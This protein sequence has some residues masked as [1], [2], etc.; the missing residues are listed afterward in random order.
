MIG[1]TITGG[2]ELAKR[3]ALAAARAPGI[4]ERK[5][6]AAAIT[7]Q[8]EVRKRMSDAGGRHPFFGRTGGRGF[9]LAARSGG[10]RRR[11][12]ASKARRIGRDLIVLVGTTD[13]HI[14]FMEDGGTIHG[15]QY[16][17][18]PLAAAQ[19][20]QGVDRWAGMSIRDIPG[21][22]LVRTL[23]GRLFAAREA[24]GTRSRRIELLYMLKRSVT[25][26]GRKV[27]ETS[28]R[29]AEPRVVKIMGDAALEIVKVANGS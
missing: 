25:H 21:A 14:A 11:V 23:R 27:F 15:N 10:S 19:T 20:A 3:L 8:G 28:R 2:D 18:I 29:D 9:T 16:L 6:N 1:I 4:E 22:F 17:R 26:R 12:V 5:L 13:K 24:G 7:V